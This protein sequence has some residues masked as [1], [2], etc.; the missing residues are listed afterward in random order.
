MSGA[1]LRTV[2]HVLPHPGG[3]GEEYVR[4]LEAMEGFRFERTYLTRAMAPREAVMSLPAL[5][6]RV[7]A[8]DLVQVHGD[9]AA[10]VC[11]PLLRTRPSVLTTHGLNL[12]RRSGGLRGRLVRRAI[13]AA[14][15]SSVVTICNSQAERD[16]V[17]ALTHEQSKLRFIPNAVEIPDDLAPFDRAA[18]RRLLGLTPSDFAAVWAGALQPN[19]DP[20][21]FARAVAEAGPPVVGLIAGEGPMRAPLEVAAS[22]N[23]RILGHRDDLDRVLRASDAFVMTSAREAIS[24]AILEAMARRLP[25]VVSD[26]PGNPEAVGEDGIITPFGDARAIADAL[27]RLVGAPELRRDLGERGRRRVERLYDSRRM[28]AATR[29]VYERALGA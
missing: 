11:M 21:T 9:A 6:R 17:R 22:P 2:L 1:T 19:K 5:R 20:M 24:L 25:V 15:S 13:R 7:R 27:R 26:R 16:E 29:A 28:V 12:L 4:L 8:F 10:I 23:L 14:V 3:G 18:Q